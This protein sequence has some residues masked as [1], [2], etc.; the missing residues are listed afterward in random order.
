MEHLPVLRE[1][2][3]LAGVSL[4]VV[5]LFQRLRLPAVVGFIATGALI[6]P[7][8]FGLIRD[9]GLIRAMSEIGVVLLLFTIGL[10]ISPADLRALGRRTLIAG[11]LQILLT[12]A[13]VAALLRAFGLHPAQALFFGMLVSLS[14]TAVVFRL[15]A[16]RIELG[17]PHGRAATGVLI[18][19]D[20]VVIPFVLGLPLLGRWL[21]GPLESPRVGL[22]QVLGVLAFL[23][24]VALV[25]FAARRAIPWVLGRA[26]RA[27]SRE[28]FLFGVLLVALGSA[29]LA[30]WAG[31]SLALGSFLAGVMLSESELR[32]QVTAVVLPFRDTLASVF[33]V[34]IGMSLE[35][36]TLL[37]S[38]LLVAGSTVTLVAIK[39]V[40]GIAALRLAGMPWRVAAAAGF[41]LAQVGEFSFVLVQAG[42]PF[43]L[44]GPSGGQAFVAGAVFSLML[45]PLLVG[46]APVWALA[47]ERRLGPM[48]AAMGRMVLEGEA[49]GAAGRAAPPA[50][51]VV[52]A[53]FGLN[54]RN[55][56]RVLKATR[57]PHVIVDLDPD[58]LRAA[59]EGSPVLL[60]DV[61]SAEIQKRAGVPRARVLVLALSDPS[62]TRQAC[63]VARSLSREVFIVVRTRYVSEIDQ[64]YGAGANQVIPE[65]F[66]TSIEIFTA[67]LREL[68]VPTN[69]IHAQIAL[70]REERYSLLRGQKLP[71]SV[72]EQ[73]DT[74]LEAGT[75]DTFLLLQHSPA[76]GQSLGALG[77]LAER[78]ARAVAVVRG[79]GALT[80]LGGDLALRV[81]DTLVL[82]G[83]HAE[84]D[85]AFERLS[86]AG[87]W[88]SPG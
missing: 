67:V 66:E 85:R 72:V 39:L 30:D 65:E 23:A 87:T 42:A 11:G 53:G 49:A 5:L 58:A 18:L 60:G 1:L 31:V 83:T 57:L 74:I 33:F 50:P 38:P 37:A 86:P 13:L 44:L 9:A 45:T 73:L 36:R 71:S 46:R 63:R 2:L 17:S 25:F 10:E 20:I 64:L 7:G 35:P 84:M 68:H 62:A 76:V 15:L 32:P 70:L 61:T 55:V 26:S 82:T 6:G 41:A 79:G 81:G 4:A 16:D 69:I 29:A 54:G 77:L 56:A 3:L 59:P 88:M 78:G 12:V 8:A 43:G 75:T 21:Q 24:G 52:I 80:D 14:S 34:A 47:L 27:R 22:G 19:Q 48:R 40:A 51:Q 28:A